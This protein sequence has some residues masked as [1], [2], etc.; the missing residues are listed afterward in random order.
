MNNEN[1]LKTNDQKFEEVFSFSIGFLKDNPEFYRMWL[2][3]IYE[4]PEEV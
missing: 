2:H 4:E 1:S 3:E